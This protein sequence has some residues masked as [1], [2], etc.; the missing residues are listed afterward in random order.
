MKSSGIDVLGLFPSLEKVGGVQASG[1]IAWE[2][3]TGGQNSK[4]EIRNACLFC[5]GR[6][7]HSRRSLATEDLV[8]N[9]PQFPGT[10]VVLNNSKLA[11]VLTALRLRSP[12]QLILIWH[13]GL[14]KLLPFLRIRQAEIALFLHGTEAWRSQ[15]WLTR[16][17]LRRVNVFLP[18]SE[19]SW[20]RFLSFNPEFAKAPHET[21][22]LGIGMPLNGPIPPPGDPPAALMISRLVLAEDYKGHR[23]MIAAWPLVLQRIPHAELWII[24][25]GDLLDVLKRNVQASGLANRIRFFG[26]VSED[27]K[28]NFL[29]R[30]RCLA[31]PSRNE[32]FG[33]VYLEAMRMG[34]P[35]L[36]ST[37]DGGR[38]PVHPPEGGLAA[39]PDNPQALADAVCRLI[40]PGSE[41]EYWSAQALGRYERHFTARHFQERLAKALTPLTR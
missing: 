34:R 20:R 4:F 8:A 22:Y 18:N 19:D 3:L 40:I 1:R 41:W 21:V 7:T 10:D 33:L 38:E 31:L 30:C 9:H 5:Y 2:G 11:A 17:L 37:L 15:Q 13:L 32:G 36:V 39:D 14:L 6:T 12:F 35:C 28:Q 26:Q 25:D 29:V 16:V 23:E 24:G 27:E